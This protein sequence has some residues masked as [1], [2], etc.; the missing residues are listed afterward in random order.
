MCSLAIMS[1]EDPEKA[2]PHILTGDTWS[3][4]SY[5]RIPQLGLQDGNC[6]G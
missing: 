5:N 2:M 3:N 6:F 4:T 1:V